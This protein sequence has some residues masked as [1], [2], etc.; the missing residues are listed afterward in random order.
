MSHLP[1]GAPQWACRDSDTEPLESI[2]PGLQSVQ[3]VLV[4]FSNTNTAHRLE[5]KRNVENAQAVLVII[6][7]LPILAHKS[8]FST[9]DALSMCG[10]QIFKGKFCCNLRFDCRRAVVS[11]PVT[12]PSHVFIRTVRLY[13]KVPMGTCR[14]NKF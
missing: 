6:F 2:C 3:L 10:L 13:C 9:G 12:S 8:H 5:T 14:P 4:C 11:L 7:R 1:L